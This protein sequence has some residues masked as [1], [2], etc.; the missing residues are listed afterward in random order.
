M[1]LYL[2]AV[3]GPS[4]EIITFRSAA[5]FENSYFQKTHFHFSLISVIMVTIRKNGSSYITVSQSTI[6]SLCR[7]ADA[8]R[9]RAFQGAPDAEFESATCSRVFRAAYQT[10]PAYTAGGHKINR[11]GSCR[12]QERTS[13]EEGSTL[14]RRISPES[15][16]LWK[17]SPLA[18]E[19]SSRWL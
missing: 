15:C 10:P 16:R 14:P 2:A 4:E 19:S 12:R 8:A 7:R 13:Q 17:W 18:T 6:C 3:T 11:G 5:L 1:W 9:E